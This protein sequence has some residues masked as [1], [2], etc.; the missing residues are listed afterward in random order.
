[1]EPKGSVSSPQDK[2]MPRWS[3]SHSSSSGLRYGSFVNSLSSLGPQPEEKIAVPTTRTYV[4]VAVLCYVNLINYME[5]YTIAGD[6]HTHT[7]GRRLCASGVGFTV[8]LSS[9]CPP[10][11]SE[12]LRYK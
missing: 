1:M 2:P 9:R 11:H 6:T 3:R 12:I 4:A 5:R 10:Q 7:Q 8:V